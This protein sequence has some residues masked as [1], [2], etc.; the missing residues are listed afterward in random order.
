LGVELW[1]TKYWLS[2]LYKSNYINDYSKKNKLF[3]ELDSIINI[4]T[5]IVKTSSQ[6]KKTKIQSKLFI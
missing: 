1:E 5:K 4:I 3:E 6:N 2:L